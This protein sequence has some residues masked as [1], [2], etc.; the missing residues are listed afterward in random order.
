MRR[1]FWILTAGIVSVVAAAAVSQTRADA[2]PAPGR[3]SRRRATAGR[4]DAARLL[5]RTAPGSLAPALA[6]LLGDPKSADLAR[7]VLEAMPDPA[8]DDAL[9]GALPRL[10][11]TLLVGTIQSIGVQRD[12][13]AVEP[14]ARLL[15]GADA[16]AAAAA[17]FALGR[18]ASAPAAQR[19]AKAE[20]SAPPAR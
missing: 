6:D 4:W 15:A 8:A 16:E 5:A 2:G 7:C 10:K 12:A 17:A 14:L 11:G 20:G 1:P 18:I 9:R 3:S 13:K 19:L